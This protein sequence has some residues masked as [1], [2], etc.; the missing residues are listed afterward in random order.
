[1]IYKL[2]IYS[3]SSFFILFFFSKIA[4]KLNLL[5]LPNKR[6]MHLKPTAY[7]GGLGISVILILSLKMFHFPY[8]EI[9]SI[10]AM[11]FLICIVGLIDDRYNLNIGGKLSLQIIPIIY[12]FIFENLY[13][14]TI[15]NYS[16]FEL[17]LGS[18]SVPF[19]LLC[20]LFLINSFNYFDGLDGVL[21]LSSLTSLAIL[22]F[23]INDENIKLFLLIISLPI[24]IFLFFNFSI[25]N[26]PKLFL[27]DSGSLLLGFIFSFIL[28][29]LANQKLS[30]PILLAWSVSLFV[31]EFIAINL[32]RLKRNINIFNAGKDHIHHVIYYK[33]NSI[34]FTNFFICSINLIFFIF[35]YCTF[36]YINSTFSLFMFIFMFI[37]FLIFRYSYFKKK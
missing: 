18:F 28:I 10:I 14:V 11:A 32:I 20:I 1:M 24:I 25:L 9:N 19:S 13:L 33:T 12:L 21:S 7:I 6:K 15:G 8:K 29:Y 2:I 34:F 5:D 37:I 4:Y 26:I 35:G 22:F 30:H 23:L 27:G 31:Y 3:I 36:K 16:Q 17:T